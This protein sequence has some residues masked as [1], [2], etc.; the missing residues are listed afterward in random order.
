MDSEKRKKE[1]LVF[2]TI[3]SR[4][5]GRLFCHILF[6]FF[7]VVTILAGLRAAAIPAER[8]VERV[9]YLLFILIFSFG[10]G[11]CFIR[12]YL[13]FLVEKFADGLLAPKRYLTRPAPLLSP[14]RNLIITGKFHEAEEM[15]TEILSEYPA[16]PVMTFALAEL[17]FL[18]I[19]DPGK[20]EIL[21][22]NYFENGPV[23]QMPENI[24]ILLLYTDTLLK[25]GKANEAVMVLK[26]E[27]GKKIYPPDDLA[28]IQ[29]RLAGLD[30]LQ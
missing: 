17:Y 21:C 2:F 3:L 1:R 20:M 13:P 18:H 8:G 26:N 25:L 23:V 16:D 9:I 5:T 12:F 14:V 22:R 4:K 6:A 15:L 24:K 27:S 10:M 30:T 29:T 19:P 7:L 28:M 11:L